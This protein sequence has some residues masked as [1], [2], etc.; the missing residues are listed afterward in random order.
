[1]TVYFLNPPPPTT[2]Y[3]VSW[4]R[5]MYDAVVRTLLGKLNCTGTLTLSANTTTTTL[6]DPRIGGNSVILF[7]PTTQHAAD[8]WGS[9]YVTAKAA[10]SCTVNHVNTS[11]TDKTFDYIVIG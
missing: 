3:T 10:G 2:E 5:A 9:I 4:A 6:N 8:S 11:E 1:M 7:T